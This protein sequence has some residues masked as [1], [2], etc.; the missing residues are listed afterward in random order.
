MNF[1]YEA[2]LNLK[3]AQIINNLNLNVNFKISNEQLFVNDKNKEPDTLYIVYKQLVGPNSFGV[4]TLPYQIVVLSEQNQLEIAQTI[5][6]TFVSEQ[7]FAV[8]K[9]GD[10]LVKHSY[11]QYSVMSNF[12][13]I[14]VGA[15]TILY[16]PAVLQVMDGLSFLRVGTS[17]GQIKIHRDAWNE[18]AD[19]DNGDIL[20]KY[21][22]LSIDYSMAGDTQQ[23]TTEELAQTEK[24]TA[25]LAIS[26]LIPVYNNRFC[27][28]ALKIMTGNND[29]AGNTAFTVSFNI[30]DVS[31]TK[32]MKITA[33]HFEDTPNEAPGLRIGMMY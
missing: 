23:F 21:L 28:E 1:D 8:T 7:N 17:Y 3:F 12:N 9:E 33:V 14:D 30:G 11:Q 15:R 2:W 5:C 18:F 19:T 22:G 16:I 26:I 4:R 20:I 13:Q 25:T 29:L 6:D 10:T 31:I 24:S 32:D 27:N